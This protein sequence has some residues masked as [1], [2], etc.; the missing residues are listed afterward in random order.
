MLENLNKKVKSGLDTYLGFDTDIIWYNTDYC[1]VYGGATRDIINDDKIN[2]IDMMVLGKSQK[3]VESVLLENGYRKLEDMAMKH[4]H[5]LY[6]EIR[7]IFEPT[8]YINDD[9]KIVQLIRPS[10]YSKQYNR[11]HK[12]INDKGDFYAMSN[13]FFELMREVD[14]ST[15]GVSF[16]GRLRENCEDAILHCLSKVYRVND[17]A[18][19][20]NPKRI[21]ERREK[22]RK[23]GYEEFHSMDKNRESYK[24]FTKILGRRDKLFLI[25]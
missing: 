12:I 14:L 20:L 22:L 7:C 15:S 6:K 8:T 10:T 17:K 2:D 19:M 1:E 23:K 9:F 4:L 11:Y 13:R 24:K 3:F 5:D 18:E 16:N 25:N 21:Y